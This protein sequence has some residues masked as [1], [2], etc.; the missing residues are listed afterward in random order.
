MWQKVS[1]C[2]R[3]SKKLSGHT[4]FASICQGLPG[5]VRSFQDVPGVVRSARGCQDLECVGKNA[6][7]SKSL[8]GLSKVSL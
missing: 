7:I 1:G 2:V 5:V 6:I 4:R 3:S 8:L